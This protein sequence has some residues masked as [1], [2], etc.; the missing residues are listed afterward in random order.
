MSAVF[1]F[2][3]CFI[4]LAV[5]AQHAK[6]IDLKIEQ[7]RTARYLLEDPYFGGDLTPLDELPLDGSWEIA[8]ES[9]MEGLH[10]WQ[11]FTPKHH[12][13]HEASSSGVY[14]IARERDQ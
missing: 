3:I 5:A 8:C 10:T 1:G 4:V 9:E 11:R 7:E 12:L 14:V 13:A 6:R 2:V